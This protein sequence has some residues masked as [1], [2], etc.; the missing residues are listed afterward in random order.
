MK[1]RIVKFFLVLVLF[2][3]VL[4]SIQMFLFGGL[5]GFAVFSRGNTLVGNINVT[6]ILNDRI[7]LNAGQQQSFIIKVT[8]DG[9]RF[10]NDCVLS[11]DGS[12]FPS[13]DSKDIKSIGPG[14]RVTYSV[15]VSVPASAS[16]GKHSGGLTLKCDEGASY[17]PMEIVIATNPFILNVTDYKRNG[18]ELNVYYRLNEYEGKPHVLNLKYS[19]VSAQGE[20]WSEDN[21]EI[22]L[23]SGEEKNG[24]LLIE[25]PKD[26]FGE[27]NLKINL[28]DGESKFES[29]SPV[30]LSK[31][32]VTGFV[33]LTPDNRQTLSYVGIFVTG[34]LLLFFFFRFLSSHNKRVNQIQSETQG[35]RFIQLDLSDVNSS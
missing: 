28:D 9:E 14:E 7:M 8:N 1:K 16:S 12:V 5:Q 10:V 15:V 32:G 34:G 31:D 33:S 4:A 11:V 3:F 22:S 30:F 24:E 29:Q 19:L 35:R 2:V 18:A 20:L 26:S 23:G 6:F 25:L 21:R 17:A 13:V 27:Y